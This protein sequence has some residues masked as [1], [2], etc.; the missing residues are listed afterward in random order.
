MKVQKTLLSVAL[1]IT[2]FSCKKD[3]TKDINQADW[4]FIQ[5]MSFRNSGEVDL[6]SFARNKANADTVKGFATALNIDHQ[7]AKDDLQYLANLKGVSISSTDTT[8]AHFKNELVATSGR[9][10]D[11]T[12]LHI[13]SVNQQAIID[14]MQ[15]EITNGQDQNIKSYTNSYLPL[16]KKHKQTADSIIAALHY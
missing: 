11:S 12:F 13:E 10:F 4:D 7:S 8:Y 16:V 2:S 9:T 1:I 14:L 6:S 5:S 3:Q 15:N